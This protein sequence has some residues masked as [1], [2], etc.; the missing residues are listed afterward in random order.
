M[1]VSVGTNI[2][3]IYK[4][5]FSAEK[6]TVRSIICNQIINNEKRVKKM[7]TT[8]DSVIIVI[9]IV[10]MLIMGYF[11]GKD[12]KDQEDFFLAGRSMP[13]LPVALSVAATM[14]SANAFIGGPGWA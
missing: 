11:I 4:Q 10:G 5:F 7:I 12:N 8:L 6:T 9:Y 14:I 13:W 3:T 2:A 1:K